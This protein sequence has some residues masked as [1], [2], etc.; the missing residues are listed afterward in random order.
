MRN[1]HKQFFLCKIISNKIKK[2]QN[3]FN[4]NLNRRISSMHIARDPSS[5][6]F[7]I[8]RDQ[9]IFVVLGSI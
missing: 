4:H 1:F 6:N 3:N 5:P 7:Y 2:K 9:F 8:D